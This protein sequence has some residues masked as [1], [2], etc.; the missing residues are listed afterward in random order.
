M[1]PTLPE[2]ALDASI[3]HVESMSKCPRALV[4]QLRSTFSY[5][6]FLPLRAMTHFGGANADIPVR[7][8]SSHFEHATRFLEDPTRLQA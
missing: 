4:A 6:R 3:L 2:Q 5:V 1:R 8:S 7:R